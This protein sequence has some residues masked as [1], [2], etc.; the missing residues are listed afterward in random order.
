[1][2]KSEHQ[3]QAGWVGVVQMRDSIWT[4]LHT[5]DPLFPHHGPSPVG[6]P[7]GWASVGGA[8]A[9]PVHSMRFTW[10]WVKVSSRG[11]EG[12]DFGLLVCTHRLTAACWSTQPREGQSSS[13]RRKVSPT[14]GWKHAKINNFIPALRLIMSMSRSEVMFLT[15]CDGTA[16]FS[17]CLSL[18]LCGWAYM[19]VGS[20]LLSLLKSVIVW[21]SFRD[22]CW[23]HWWNKS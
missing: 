11:E 2:G 13:A 20:F 19:M 22:V 9:A 8:N 21:G 5:S 14:S 12:A 7:Q 23:S 10:K 18:W 6:S 16:G 17:L 3:Q 1:M 15:S 4:R